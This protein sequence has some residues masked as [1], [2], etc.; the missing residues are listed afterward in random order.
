VEEDAPK[1]EKK[2]N[3]MQ[4]GSKVF[5]NFDDITKVIPSLI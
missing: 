3:I 5:I 2:E 1:K 4:I